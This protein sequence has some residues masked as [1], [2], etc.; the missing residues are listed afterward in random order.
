MSMSGVPGLAPGGAFAT[1][2][3]F[4]NGALNLVSIHDKVPYRELVY[5]RRGLFNPEMIRTK[6]PSRSYGLLFFLVENEHVLTD[7]RTCFPSF[8][9]LWSAW[10]GGLGNSHRLLI[11]PFRLTLTKIRIH[12]S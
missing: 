1:P 11:L 10:I 12:N 3:G 7:L 9:L 2:G 4:G 8:H 5:L 6:E